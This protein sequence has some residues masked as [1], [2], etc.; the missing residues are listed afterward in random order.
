M[1]YVCN[2]SVPCSLRA[3]NNYAGYSKYDNE[4]PN[5]KDTL[6]YFLTLVPEGLST[7]TIVAHYLHIFVP[8]LS[9]IQSDALFVVREQHIYIIKRIGTKWL[10]LDTT[11]KNTYDSIQE[12]SIHLE[13]ARYIVILFP[14]SELLTLRRCIRLWIP[15]R[16]PYYIDFKNYLMNMPYIR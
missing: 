11:L 6:D 9:L 14:T 15:K 2:T 10:E 16:I 13:N 4:L 12:V 3:W 5:H 7:I 8:W 1:T